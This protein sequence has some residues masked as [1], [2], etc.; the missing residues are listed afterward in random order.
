VDTITSKV[1][2]KIHA[3]E[4]KQMIK[5]AIV[6]S[7]LVLA[8]VAGTSGVAMADEGL[9]PWLVRVRLLD[10]VT[11][12]SSD[13]YGP[14]PSDAIKVSGRLQPDVDIS[15]FFTRNI[16][17]ELVLSYPV[18]HTVDVSHGYIGTFQ[19]L[20]PT[21]NLQYHFDPMN[22]FQPYV[23]AGVTYLRTFNVNLASGGLGLTQNNWGG[24]LQ[25][26]LDYRIDQHWS[27][28]ADLKKIWINVGV[29]GGPGNPTLLNLHPDPYLIGLG[30]GYH[31]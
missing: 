26:G 29:T 12:R 11:D 8:G 25:V 3:K 21:L 9:T 22:G 14:I 5:K 31:F 7:A 17:A 4:S 16:A 18:S 27:L 15:Y 1:V 20:P 10:I 2:D 19:E 28:N 23:G 13:S 30:V 24:D 6:T